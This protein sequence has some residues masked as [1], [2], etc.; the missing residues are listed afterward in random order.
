M[1]VAS[2]GSREWAHLGW[3]H[4]YASVA[5]QAGEVLVEHQSDG[6]LASARNTAAERASGTHL[7][8]LDA[9]DQLAPGYVDAMRR[10]LPLAVGPSLFVPQVQYVGRAGRAQA[11]PFFYPE[12]DHRKGNWMVIG[13]MV[14]RDVFLKVGGFDERWPIYEDWCL[15]ARLID[16]GCKPVKVPE[17]VYLAQRTPGSRNHSKSRQGRVFWHQKI[18]AANW[19]DLYDQTTPDEDARET[20]LRPDGRPAGVL[21]FLQ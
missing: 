13:T 17:A 7:I 10:A 4:A 15:L 3:R 2:F 11:Q 6:T 14:P 21:R 18:G 9:D 1:C 8:F 20:L 16:A 5:A 12:V 19:P